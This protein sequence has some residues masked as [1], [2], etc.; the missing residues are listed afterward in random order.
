MM[1]L[2][3]TSLRFLYEGIE[4]CFRITD[5]V[6]DGSSLPEISDNLAQTLTV[7]PSFLVTYFLPNEA[8][9]SANCLAS[10]MLQICS[11][12]EGL[13]AVICVFF[14]AGAFGFRVSNLQRR[15]HDDNPSRLFLSLQNSV[16]FCS[17]LHRVQVFSDCIL[18]MRP[19]SEMPK[20]RDD[21][22]T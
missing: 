6:C 13:A 19:P 18:A 15:H 11:T 20:L 7:F 10:G 14:G 8:I 16:R 1:N 4:N 17:F 22:G 21:L 9:D 5:T 12:W 2:P 3:D